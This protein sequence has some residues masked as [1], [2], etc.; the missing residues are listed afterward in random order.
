M[1]LESTRRHRSNRAVSPAV[2]SVIITGVMVALVTVAFAF[3][4][5]FL[6]VRMAEGEFNSAK[7]TMQTLGLQVDDVAWI[8]GRTETVRYSSKYG[9]VS[10]W[11][12]LNYSIYVNTTTQ[13]NLRFYTGLT[14]II[15]FDMP[16]SQ[17]S[18]GGD[19]FELVSPSSDNR[20]LFNATS[21]PVTRTFVVE[22]L[23]MADGSFIRVVVAP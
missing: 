18:L 12:A 5:N 7:Q 19:Y 23:P 9:G 15:S 17:Y 4:S 11:Q 21:A 22:K 16:V 6:L 14:G 8:V 13:S 1:A 3:A 2:S 10:L 20:F